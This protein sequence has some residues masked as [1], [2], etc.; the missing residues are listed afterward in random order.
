MAL[1]VM[2]GVEGHQTQQP[3]Q[4]RVHREGVNEGPAGSGDRG[5]GLGRANGL[6]QNEEMACPGGS[7]APR[8]PNGAGRVFMSLLLEHGTERMVCVSMRRTRA[9]QP[10]SP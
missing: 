3:E 5:E 4:R 10:G 2:P 1:P 6:N 7:E 8:R 9:G